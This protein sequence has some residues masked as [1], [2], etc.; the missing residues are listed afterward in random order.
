MARRIAV[1]GDDAPPPVA[2]VLRRELERL[3]SESTLPEV[4]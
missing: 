3:V 2:T 4:G 1:E